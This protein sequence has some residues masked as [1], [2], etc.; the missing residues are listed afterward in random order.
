MRRRSTI[1]SLLCAPLCARAVRATTTGE[2]EGRIHR[3]IATRNSVGQLRPRSTRVTAVTEAVG[4]SMSSVPLAPCVAGRASRRR[5][6]GR[7]CRPADADGSR[8]RQTPPQSSSCTEPSRPRVLS[9]RTKPGVGR[10]HHLCRNRRGLALL[11]RA[12]RPLV[13]QSRLIRDGRSHRP[14]P[15]P[16]RTQNGSWPTTGTSRFRSPYRSWQ[17]V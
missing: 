14:S 15:R 12:H 9:V 5:C 17:P 11:R 1:E 6:A 16:A 3:T 2:R 4:F 10:R 13:T 8:R 7:G